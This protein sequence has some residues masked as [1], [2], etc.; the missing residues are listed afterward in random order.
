MHCQGT[1]MPDK[2]LG[3]PIRIHKISTN[4]L[5]P[6]VNPG[7]KYYIYSFLSHSSVLTEFLLSL[8]HLLYPSASCCLNAAQNPQ[9]SFPDPHELLLHWSL[10]HILSWHCSVYTEYV[11]CSIVDSCAKTEQNVAVCFAEHTALFFVYLL[12]IN[13]G[14][15]L[16]K[17]SLLVD[18]LVIAFYF[19]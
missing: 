18:F 1:G 13:L 2:Y 12:F 9:S 15:I 10:K 4:F 14:F 11:S 8:P 16:F 7:Y 19:N 5:L 3:K 6:S 17:N